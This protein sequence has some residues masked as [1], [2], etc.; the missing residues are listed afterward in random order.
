V[1]LNTLKCNYLTPLDLKGLS[2]ILLYVD[3]G[4]ELKMAKSEFAEKEE[5]LTRAFAK[6]ESLLDELSN[7]QKRKV[8]SD[9]GDRQ[10]EVDKLR[11]EL[12]VLCFV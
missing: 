7:L 2:F 3:L 8:S 1:V 5:E 10:Q 11:L 9:A 12:E 4:M 6:V